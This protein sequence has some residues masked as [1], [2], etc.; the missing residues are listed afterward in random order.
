MS[1]LRIR[2]S[3]FKVLQSSTRSRVVPAIAWRT[4]SQ[5][6]TSVKGQSASPLAP[7]G[8]EAALHAAEDPSFKPRATLFKEFDLSKR[9]AVVSGGNRGLGLEMALAMCE[10]GATVYCMDLPETAGKEWHATQKYVEGLGVEGARL[11]YFSVDVTDQQSVWDKVQRVA[12]AEGRM[13]VCIAAAGI[14]HGADAL[15]Y[16]AAEFRKVRRRQIHRFLQI[17]L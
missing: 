7:I 11:E 1:A 3:A 14:L 2:S 5:T 4:F 8:V 13:D 12:D 6:A 10:A 9:V 16:P 17:F 15:E